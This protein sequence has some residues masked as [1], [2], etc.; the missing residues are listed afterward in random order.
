MKF[1][2]SL[3]L[4][5][6]VCLGCRQTELPSPKVTGEKSPDH[7]AVTLVSHLGGSLDDDPELRLG[8]V[9]RVVPDENEPPSALK[10]SVLIELPL[11]TP[12][13]GDDEQL[14]LRGYAVRELSEHNSNFL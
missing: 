5:I 4:L 10:E 9:L 1:A 2:N 14:F 3:L 13:T 12:F 11:K 6:V 8:E 7:R